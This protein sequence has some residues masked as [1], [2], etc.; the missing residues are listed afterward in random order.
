[1]TKLRLGFAFGLATVL[2]IGLFS[3]TVAQAGGT[4]TF[5][6]DVIC[7]AGTVGVNLSD[8]HTEGVP[9]RGS[10]VVVRGD[11][12]P[13]GTLGSAETPAAP[14]GEE[15]LGTWR[16]LFAAL[17]EGPLAGAVTYYFA[18]EDEKGKESMVLVKG[19]NSHL[20]PPD[21]IPR[22]LAVVGGTYRYAGAYGEVREVVLRQN[23]TGCFDLRFYFKIRVPLAFRHKEKRRHRGRWPGY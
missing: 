15:V 18:F 23:E 22:K 2:S 14:N 13:E 6:V 3:S 4:K 1:M 5:A 9:P 21:S 7:D 16:C 8:S 12:F 11:I 10:V 17:N 20:P 19:I